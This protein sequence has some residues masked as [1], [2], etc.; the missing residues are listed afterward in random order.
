MERLLREVPEGPPMASGMTDAGAGA[1]PVF[2]LQKGNLAS[3]GEEVGPGFPSILGPTSLDARPAASAVSP[4]SG[5]RQALA[6][7]LTRPDHPLTARV[8]VNRLWQNHFGRGIVA[9]PSDF[10]TQGTEPTHPAL[11]DWLATEFVARGWS[12]K[13]MHRLMV[14][15]A[16]YRQSSVASGRTLD[17]DP[18]NALFSR[19]FR[20][21]LEGEAVRDALLAVSG[22]LDP[23]VGG[24]S[25]FPDL[26]PG[27]ET[28]GGWTR[29]AAAAD[30]NRRSIYV[31]VRRNL[32]YPLFDAFDAPDSNT[33]CP[34]RNVSV[35]APQ[36][37]M[38][39][40]SDLVLDQARAFAGRVL[41]ESS[42]RHDLAALVERAYRL[43]LA[44][45]PDPAE[46]KRGITFLEEQPAL[47][48]AR[49]E[50][51]RSLDLPRPMPDGQDPASAAALVDFCHVLLNLNEFVFVD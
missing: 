26:P 38:L 19:M 48:S 28:R 18:E 10:G 22:E 17:E 46:L 1:P 6:E 20:R 33:T 25:V 49:A 41:A 42:T 35:N 51:A 36:A 4:T 9:T 47:L 45:R 2:L 8:M 24:A 5:R 30:R 27:I 14:T 23:R 44:R 29:S 40:N 12:L 34:D 7:W 32:K 21:R 39:L 15:S 11:L 13:A 50:T 31:F 3:P 16:T 37:L 43:A